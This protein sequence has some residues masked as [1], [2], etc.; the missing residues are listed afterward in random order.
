MKFLKRIIFF[1]I[2]NSLCAYSQGIDN[3]WMMGYESW[4]GFP[5]GGINIDFNSGTPNIYGVNRIQNFKA[6]NA[7]ITDNS[8]NLLFSSNGV[9]IADATG[10]TMLLSL[11]HI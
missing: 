1:I 9:W 5:Y 11:I 4:A 7:N 8:G 6:T 2:V 10:D 3:L